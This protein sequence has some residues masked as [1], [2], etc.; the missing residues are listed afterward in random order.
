MHERAAASDALSCSKTAHVATLSGLPNG[1]LLKDCQYVHF[2]EKNKA[3]SR[4]LWRQN[5][6]QGDPWDRHSAPRLAQRRCRHVP[7][8]SCERPGH[9]SFVHSNRRRVLGTLSV[10]RD[11]LAPLLEP[12]ACIVCREFHSS[13]SRS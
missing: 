10:V 11:G 2:V 7:G 12:A 6:M 3:M 8:G 4:L 13:C 1:L 9:P 5:N